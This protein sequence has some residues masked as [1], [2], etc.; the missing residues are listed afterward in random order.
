M[1]HILEQNCL[2][3][4]TYSENSICFSYTIVNT[5]YKDN[6]NNNNNNNTKFNNISNYDNISSNVK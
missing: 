5:L 4:T 3:F 2:Y 1:Y 6:K